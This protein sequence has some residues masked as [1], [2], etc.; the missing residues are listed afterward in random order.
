MLGVKFMAKGNSSVRTRNFATVVYPESAPENWQDILVE[1]FVP[2][3]ISPLHDSDI[4]P[5][6]EKKKEHY[7]VVIMFDSVKTAEQAKTLF[8]KIGGVGCE[9]VQSIRGYARYLCHLDNPEKH[10]YQQDKVRC[11]CGADYA[12]TIGLAYDKYKALSEME[13]FCERYN[14]LSYYVLARYATVYRSDWSR[15][16]KD[17][18]TLYMKEYLQSRKWSRDNGMN[19]IIDESTGEV[20]FDCSGVLKENLLQSQSIR[21]TLIFPKDIDKNSSFSYN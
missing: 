5:G 9:I 18:G 2:A 11:L 6:G 13:E 19:M 3:F 14:I 17:C 21:Q 1:Q 16:L 10:Q 15:I 4:N 12:A 8:E 7:H 20:I